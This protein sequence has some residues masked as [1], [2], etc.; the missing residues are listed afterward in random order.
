M[1][2]GEKVTNAGL[3]HMVPLHID[4]CS[5]QADCFA[6]PLG[7]FTLI[8]GIEWLRKL[9]PTDGTTNYLDMDSCSS[10]SGYARAPQR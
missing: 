1:A 2:N 6:I 9:G 3:C 5:S 7:G 8:L 4:N 10:A